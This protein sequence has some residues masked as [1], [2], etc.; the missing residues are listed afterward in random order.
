MTVTERLVQVNECFLLHVGTKGKKSY[1]LSSR[2]V[3][4]VLDCI[5]LGSLLQAS[6]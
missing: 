2:Q 1:R 3:D 4:A 6:E 5:F